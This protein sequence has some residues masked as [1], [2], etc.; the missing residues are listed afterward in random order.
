MLKVRSLITVSLISLVVSG[1]ANMLGSATEQGNELRI[2]ED[3]KPGANAKQGKYPITVRMAGYSDARQV[4]SPRRLGTSNSRILGLTGKDIMSDRDA[5]E[6]VA[7][8]LKKRLGDAGLQI[9]AADAANA[10]FQLNGAVKELSIDV[11]DRDY[12]NIA[13]ESTL[14]EVSSGKVIWSGL[15]VE[16]ADR[17][18]G[19]SGNGKKDVAD[20]LKAKLGVVSN[21]TTESILS[22]LMATRPSMFNMDVGI[23]PVQGVT[24]YS[25]TAGSAAVAPASIQTESVAANGTLVI[26]SAPSRA[27]VYVDGVYFGLTPLRAEFSTGIHEVSIRLDGYQTSTEKVSVRKGDSTEMDIKLQR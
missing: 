2:R 3:A 25:N 19:T 1:C 24:I 5:T 23:K 26:G 10:Q 27:K 4:D 13:I 12:V 6:V 21:K 20:F 7:E 16:R 22:V 18:A 9:V 17:Y 8:S 11:K 14:T 15:V